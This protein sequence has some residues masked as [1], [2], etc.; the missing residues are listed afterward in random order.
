VTVTSPGPGRGGVVGWVLYD[1]ANTIFSL[2]IVSFYFSVWL[3]NVAGGSDSQV[4]LANSLS[5]AVIVVASPFLGALTD[6]SPRRLPYLVVSTLL[7]V[8]ATLTLGRFGIGS[9]LLAFG[10][11]NVAYQA[12]LQFY[13]SLL[14]VVSTPANRGRIGGIGIGMGYVGAVMGLLVGRALLGDLEGLSTEARTGRYAMVFTASAGLFLLFALPA[15]FLVDEPRRRVSGPGREAMGRAVRQVTR[16]LA[17]LREHPRLARFLLGRA[18]YTDAVNTVIAFMGIYVTNAVGFTA[19]Q[20][21]LVM[22]VAIVCAALGG[23]AWG[24]V[25]DRLG[26]A[27]TLRIV[28][29][30]WVVTFAWTAL[31]GFLALPPATFW[32]VPPLAGI[33]LGGTWTA[34]RPF[35][36]RLTPADRVG[37]FYGLYGMVGRFAAVTGPLLWALVADTL[38]LGRP[39]AV[40]S[41][42]VFVVA[43]MIV[44]APVS[45]EPHSG[46]DDDRGPHGAKS[47]R[48]RG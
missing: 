6:Q 42:L 18:L 39:A 25:V 11:A 47:P 28:L 8:A 33:A 38:G 17:S 16:T 13:D 45:D 30:L 1:L 4:A 34:D 44:L 7:C 31:V 26:P 5:M 3:V 19:G 48:S 36:L 29:Y 2:N 15:F 41:L 46:D 40:A 20:A 37:E 35:L 23:F 14:P 24:P 10:A 22:L 27:R 12:G 43:S 9:A 32:V 21:Q